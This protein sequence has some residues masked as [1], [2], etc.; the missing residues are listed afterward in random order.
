M[1]ISIRKLPNQDLYKVYNKDTKEVFSYGTTLEKAQA[2]LR[3]LYMLHNQ[4][5]KS[6]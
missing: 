2:Q 3:F 4:N 1:P 6:K 5:I